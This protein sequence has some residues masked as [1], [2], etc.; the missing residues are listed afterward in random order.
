MDAFLKVVRP[1]GADNVELGFGFACLLVEN[2]AHYFSKVYEEAYR[3]KAPS[4]EEIFATGIV[5]VTG[6][7]LT[8][9]DENVLRETCAY[10]LLLLGALR[11]ENTL[12]TWTPP[13]K[14]PQDLLDSW[15]AALQLKGESPLRIKLY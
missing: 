11:G 12:M 5:H 13:A 2:K 7:H 9:E 10:Y 15:L 14:I 6:A 4:L 3:K 8:G 1:G